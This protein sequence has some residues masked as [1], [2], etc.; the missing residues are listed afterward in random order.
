MHTD[1]VMDSAAPGITVAGSESRQQFHSVA[2]FPVEQQSVVIV[3]RLMGAIAG[4]PVSQPVTV[5]TK[6][7][8]STCG[9]VSKSDQR[10][11]GVC[12]W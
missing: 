2:D 12:G 10:F 1:H 8:C 7:N 11:C 4:T 6:L 9:R 3:L 5:G